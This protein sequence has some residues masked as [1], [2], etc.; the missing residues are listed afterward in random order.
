VLEQVA[1]ILEIPIE[2]IKH[3]DEEAITN[4]ISNTVN[5]NDHTTGNALFSYYQ[6]LIP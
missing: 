5:N 2:A 6:R 3:F 1:K 4:V